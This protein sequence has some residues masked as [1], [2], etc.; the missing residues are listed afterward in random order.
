MDCV[1]RESGLGKAKVWTVCS[2]NMDW[3]KGECGL[4]KGRVWTG[5]S[6]TG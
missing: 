3:V 5:Y 4:S 6:E 1:K 2:E